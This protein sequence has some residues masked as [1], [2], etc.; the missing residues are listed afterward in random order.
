MIKRKTLLATLTSLAFAAS[1]IA[2]IQGRMAG[3]V[4][5]AEGVPLAGVAIT[6]T[7]PNI[8]TYKVTA[9]TDKKGNYGII[10]NDATIPYMI[11]YELP[12]YT[13]HVE[14][15][16]LSTV[17]ATTVDVK[18]QKASGQAA[19]AAMSTS[20]Q[21][22]TAYNDGVELLNSGD[23]AGAEAKFR[24]AAT[25]N[26]DLPQAWQGIAVIA[27]QNKEWAKVLEAAE[28]ATD[29]DP[30]MT[31][32]YQMMAVAA[33]QK[34]DK[35]TAAQWQARYEAA[36]PETPEA[37]YNK[38]VT[39]LNSGKM[40]DASDYFEKAVEAKPDFALAHYQLGV[41]SLSLKKNDVAK[42]HLQKYLEL[43]PDGT[44]AATA[45]ELLGMLK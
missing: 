29:L 33:E 25:K 20:D 15:K 14:Q 6:V 27:Y 4:T 42:E 32:L 31:S 34:G 43:A 23:K 28:K 8:T 44:E 30:T 12:G 22:A 36:S 19:P 38:G 45:K 13:T 1:A 41:V 7:T 3:T 18:L 16:K 17:E 11:K 10:V 39:A 37:I 24:E 26:P 5:D 35:A 40:Q 2:G 9:K 21:A